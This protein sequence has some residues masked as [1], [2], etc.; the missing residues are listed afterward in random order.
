[1]G[2]WREANGPEEGG[3]GRGWDF[4]GTGTRQT[5]SRIVE[6]AWE[7]GAGGVQGGVHGTVGGMEISRSYNI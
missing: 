6:M 5:K 4:E 2:C 7:G 3:D 1:M